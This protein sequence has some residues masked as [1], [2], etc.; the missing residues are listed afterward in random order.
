[1]SIFDPKRFELAATPSKQFDGFGVGVLAC[2]S[3]AQSGQVRGLLVTVW[4]T[5]KQL[6][7]NLASSF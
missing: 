1:M 3:P 2:F 7:S 4:K 5:Q 6:P